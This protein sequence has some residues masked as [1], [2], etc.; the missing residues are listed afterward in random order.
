MFGKANKHTSVEICA[1]AGG[2]AVGLHRAGFTHEAL[3]EIDPQA[4]E[5]LRAN[6]ARLEWRDCQVWQQDLNEFTAD[7]LDIEPGRLSLLAGGVPC[8]PFSMAGKQL[9][10]D[11]ER[12]IFPAMLN[13]VRYLQPRAV[14][15]ENVRGLL[16][17]EEKF[18]AYRAS[19]RAELVDAGYRICGW[20]VMEARDYGV[21]QLRPRAI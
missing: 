2:Q 3:V 4:C 17:P 11:D 12:D 20:S 6:V 19:I 18:A 16:E 10:Q 7:Q 14:M 15:V 21:P 9:G 8:P 13:M 5:T 1:G